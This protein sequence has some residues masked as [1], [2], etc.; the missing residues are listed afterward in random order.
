MLKTKSLEILNTFSN[1]EFRRFADFVSSPYHNTNKKLVALTKALEKF[2]PQFE[3]PA[4]TK[5]YLFTK[6]FGQ[7]KYNDQMMRNLFSEYLKICEN[8]IAKLVHQQ[9]FGFG[10]MPSGPA[11]LSRAL[12]ELLQEKDILTEE[13]IIDRLERLQVTSKRIN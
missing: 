9:I 12:A 10:Q 1:E 5:E 2:Y 4:L 3:L 6:I 13:E 7:K 11:D 8:Y